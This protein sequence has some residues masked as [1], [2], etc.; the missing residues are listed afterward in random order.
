MR[1]HA[2]ALS[3]DSTP[4]EANPKLEPSARRRARDELT[5][6]AKALTLDSRAR[7]L[8]SFTEIELH[9]HI[10]SLFEAMEPDYTVAIT[11]GSDERGKDLVLVKQDRISTH[12]IGVVVKKGDIRAKTVGDVDDLVKRVKPAMSSGAVK[13]LAEIQSQVTQAFANPAEVTTSFAQLPVNEVHVLLV[14]AMSG[15]ARRR[16]QAELPHDSMLVVR[17]MEWLT[18][19]FTEYYPQVYFEGRVVDFI[20][21]IIDRLE[22]SHWLASSGKTLTECYVDPAV[23]AHDKPV[24]LD[25]DN[26]KVLLNERRLP[27]SELGSVLQHNQRIVLVGDPGAGKSTALAKLALDMLRRVYKDL[28]RGNA[29]EGKIAIPLIVQGRML[30]SIGTADE[31]HAASFTDPEVAQRFAVGTLLV[32][33]LD[34]VPAADRAAVLEHARA[35]SDESGCS[36]LVTS[37]R[38]D[39]IRALPAGFQK[40]EV[41]PLEYG[42][43]LQLFKKLVSDKARLD[44]LKDSLERIRSQ[45]PMAPLSL[46]LLIKLV[47]ENKEV[48]ASITELYERFLDLVLGRHD[49]D[50]GISVLFEYV[51][52]GSFLAALAYDEFLCKDRL[53]MTR[54]EFDA[55]LSTYAQTFGWDGGRRQDFVAELERAGVIDIRPDNVAFCHRSFLD[56][57]AAYHVVDKREEIVDLQDFLVRVYFD[58]LW[59]DVVFFYAGL[60][61]EVSPALLKAIFTH[62][63]SDVPGV[64]DKYLMPRLLQAGW[65]SPAKTKADGLRDALSLV[66]DIR[67]RMS[68]I[69]KGAGASIPQLLADIMLVSYSEL[70]MG[71]GFL[72]EQ[73]K[74]I[75]REL[76]SKPSRDSL[77]QALPLLWAFHRFIPQDEQQAA[78]QSILSAIPQ[79][80]DISPEDSSRLL[81]LLM[82]IGRRDKELVASLKKRLDRVKKRYPETFKMLLPKAPKGFRRKPS[83]DN[84]GG[85]RGNPGR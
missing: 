9:V 5:R 39:L 85:D 14:G 28:T 64:L 81:L 61:R 17:D 26:L 66:P 32:D 62:E 20:Q 2:C 82:I 59:Q 15:I 35:I 51:V 56:Y 1:D 40:F 72:Y 44:T 43:A 3:S 29:P 42:Q 11:H 24:R 13:T 77:F 84:R 67:E 69:F 33:A 18:R 63:V 45:I 22:T 52:K 47:E 55:Y 65:N 31:L 23:V 41:L 48:P 6:H 80:T 73:G 4:V 25:H 34:E 75:L 68:D 76:L 49:R 19:N 8:A 12:V 21:S 10:K 30:L 58:S 38:V 78:I 46:M 71:S 50:K 37:R 83:R 60:R 70:A 27:F 57:F 54:P 53:E 79:A 36:L 16:L 7:I 74:T